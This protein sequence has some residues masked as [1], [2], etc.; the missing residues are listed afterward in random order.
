[1]RPALVGTC[2][3]GVVIA[4]VGAGCASTGT[5]AKPE[6]SLSY[7]ERCV[8]MVRDLRVYCRDGLRNGKVAHSKECLSRQLE[9][10]KVCY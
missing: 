9:L 1:M 7:E 2:L 10:R 6:A 3:G 8:R 4:F 5:H